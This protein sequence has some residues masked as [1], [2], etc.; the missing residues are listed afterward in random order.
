V[1]PGEPPLRNRRTHPKALI[2]YLM[3]IAAGGWRVRFVS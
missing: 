3:G 2:G 1:K